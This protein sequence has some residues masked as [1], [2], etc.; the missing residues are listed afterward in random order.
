MRL[1]CRAYDV[2]LSEAEI[3]ARGFRSFDEFFTRKL[4]PNARPIASDP[5]AIVSPAD[6]RIE[7]IGTIDRDATCVVKGTT[8]RVA[9]LI[10]DERDG[11]RFEGGQYGIVYLSPRDY[12]RVHAPVGGRVSMARHVP[13]TLFPV[14]AIGL[15]HIHK[16]F[17]RNERIV[18]AQESERYGRVVTVMVAAIGV[19]HIS[20]SFDASLATNVGT[21]AGTRV[22]GDAAPSVGRGEELGIFH[23]GSTAIIFVEANRKLSRTK[24]PGDRVVMGEALLTE[25]AS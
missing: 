22:Y 23:L 21:E 13:G 1:Y 11:A 17:A 12:H 4:K 24:R 15:R 9:E 5:H 16:L 3:P 20:V 18:I 2:D 14:N 19:G 25:R 10:G 7:D 6:G 8:Y